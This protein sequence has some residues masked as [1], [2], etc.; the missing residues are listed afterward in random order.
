MTE[1]R[2]VLGYEGLYEVSA[3]G[4]VRSMDRT[5]TRRGKPM[6]IKGKLIAEAPARGGY[7]QV[8]IS[9]NG[10]SALRYVA[11]LV[12]EAFHGPRPTGKFSAHGN[13]NRQDNSEGNLSWKTRK[14]NEAD[15]IIHGT[16]PLGSK[17]GGAKLTNEQAVNVHRL[18]QSGK[19]YHQ[20]ADEM[21]IG[22]HPVR[23][24]CGRGHYSNAMETV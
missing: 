8:R 12:C 4:S 21:G 3:V 20:I 11:N 5:V 13:G 7:L 10:K 17:V 16:K 19:T 23:G 1:W 18:R 15:K 24:I 22:Y 2:P 6:S 9:K 14:E